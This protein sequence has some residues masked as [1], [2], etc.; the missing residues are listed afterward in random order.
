MN[1]VAPGNRLIA[2]MED[3]DRHVLLGLT[4]PF[5]FRAGHVFH[6][7]GDTVEHVYFLEDGFA[8]AVAALHDGRTVETLMFGREGAP[9]AVTAFADTRAAARVIAHVAGRARRIEAVRLRA[10]VAERPGVRAVLG[11]YVAGVQAELE[12]SVA[13]NALHRAEQRLSKWL[14]RCHDRNDGC[15]FNLTQEHLASILGAQRTTVNEAAQGLQKAGAISY[16]RGRINVRDRAALE[17][18]SCECY[19]AADA[20]RL[21]P[22]R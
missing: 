3:A 14:L 17:R 12:R 18:S 15:A 6:E 22:S 11:A 16:S 19:R 20:Y 2:Q 5:D 10:L 21:S 1:Q 9:V 4:I 7:A 8:S 13:C